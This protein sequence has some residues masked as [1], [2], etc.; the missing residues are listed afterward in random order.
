VIIARGLTKQQVLAMNSAMAVGNRVANY[1]RAGDTITPATLPAIDPSFTLKQSPLAAASQPSDAKKENEATRE[2]ARAEASPPPPPP[3]PSG[4][5]AVQSS[6]LGVPGAAS[7]Q[8]ATAPAARDFAG[9][10]S[11]RAVA[12]T[13]ATAP[14]TTQAALPFGDTDAGAAAEDLVDVV[15]L[16]QPDADPAFM[17]GFEQQQQVLP[18]TGVAAP[19]PAATTPATRHAD[20]DPAATSP[21]AVEAEAPPPPASP[22]PPDDAPDAAPAPDA[23]APR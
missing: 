3:T 23:P 2:Y 10:L 13:A 20:S 16:V 15:I 5:P 18:N 14:A 11:D 6:T 19:S 8:P 22:V 7:T 21:A 9:G 1:S 4:S 12:T 17:D